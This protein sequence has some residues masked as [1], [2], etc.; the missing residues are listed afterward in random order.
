MEEIHKMAIA[1]DGYSREGTEFIYF[2][3]YP[4]TI[5]ADSVTIGTT[6]DSR[7]YYLGS[8]GYYYA[9]VTA[10]PF[11]SFYP[12]DDMDYKFS[13]DEIV[14]PSRETDIDSTVY[15][16]KKND[17]SYKF[18]TNEVI[19]SGTTY[20]FKVEPIKW[21]IFK[22]RHGEAFIICDSIIANMR[23]DASSNNYEKSEIR[24]WLNNEFYTTAFTVLQKELILVTNVD[25]SVN[26]KKFRKNS[27]A[28]GNFYACVNTNDKIFLPGYRDLKNAD[29]ILKFVTNIFKEPYKYFK[30]FN[31]NS[32]VNVR[33][34]SDYSRA[35]GSFIVNDDNRYYGV[36]WWW[37]RSPLSE[38]YSTFVP[39]IDNE[40][41]INYNYDTTYIISGVVPAL[42]IKLS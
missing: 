41:F 7:G 29:Y 6:A 20:Y 23:Y 25:N 13:T 26:S 38:D 24:A 14:L 16:T 32:D 1:T 21:R 31:R 36:G 22:K 28:F 5:K 40:G 17:E 8:D 19:I 2:G 35:I 10:T 3:E 34:T 27:N 42:K 15:E 37:L 12:T 30:C 9:K 11:I 39:G 18:S 4:Q 33:I